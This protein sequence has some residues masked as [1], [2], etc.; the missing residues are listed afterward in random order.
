[1]KIIR[2]IKYK[3]WY[4]FLGFLKG[5]IEKK[6]FFENLDLGKEMGM[7]EKERF[8]SSVKNPYSLVL[9]G[10]NKNVK[11]FKRAII[12]IKEKEKIYKVLSINASPKDGSLII[13]FPYCTKNEAYIFQHKYKY[14]K[15]GIS[16]IKRSEITKEFIVNNNTK[17]S[18]HSSGFVQLSGD[19]ILSGIDISTGEPNGVG[20]FSS[21]LS[22]P[23]KSGPTF[24]YTC[25]GLE[26]G[27]RELLNNKNNIQYVILDKDKDFFRTDT[28]SSKDIYKLDFFILPKQA[29][30]YVYEY[31]GEPFINH[32]LGN[33]LHA[34]GK[35]FTQPVVDLENFKGVLSVFPQ[36]SSY[37][38][39]KSN[40]GF[41]VHSPGGSNNKKNKFH[42][43][44]NFHLICPRDKAFLE[45]NYKFLEYKKQ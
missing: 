42:T 2:F 41:S 22:D 44:Y 19:G 20:V 5:R 18:I 9:V 4:N 8:I 13:A 21:P 32:V 10:L 12:C 1:M 25:W 40:S 24:A 38:S 45:K 27:Y 34:P 26:H 28:E 14:N 37:F 35:N 36:I 33:Y 23:V 39:K 29:N 17:L 11:K 7:K 3:I 15:I 43:G 16:T 6:V 31:R 30:A